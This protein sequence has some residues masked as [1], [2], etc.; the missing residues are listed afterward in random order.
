[1]TNY[2]TR[3]L[4]VTH[5]KSQPISKY[6]QEINQNDPVLDKKVISNQGETDI[7]EINEIHEL[8]S[9]ENTK[10]K[11]KSKISIKLN[12]NIINGDKKSEF[13][14]KESHP[15]KNDS[16]NSNSITQK[17]ERSSISQ[18]IPQKLISRNIIDRDFSKNL[19]TLTQKIKKSN[20]SAINKVDLDEIQEEN[21]IQE[22]QLVD[23]ERDKSDNIYTILPK[24]IKWVEEGNKSKNQ[25]LTQLLEEKENSS[26]SD[27][28][29]KHDSVLSVQNSSRTEI[30]NKNDRKTENQ[31]NREKIDIQMEETREYRLSIGSINMII[32]GYPDYKEEFLKNSENKNVSSSRLVKGDRIGRYYIRI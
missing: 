8:S 9:R 16:Q 14:E 6:K 26:L 15:T 18:N 31:N 22:S 32:E 12:S 29:I 30:S 2:F 3:I 7:T 21:K 13:I 19:T 1:M 20:Q 28:Q 4:E 27:T 23:T 24:V 17:M 10:L 25:E 5:G 11:P